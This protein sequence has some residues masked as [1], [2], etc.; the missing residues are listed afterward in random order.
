VDFAQRAVLDVAP[1]LHRQLAGQ[2]AVDHQHVHRRVCALRQ[3][4][5]DHRLERDHLAA[6]QAAVGADQQLGPGVVDAQGQVVR[7]EAAEHHRVHRADARASQ[8]GDG[9][10]HRVRHV[11]H[12][13]VALLH[14]Q[15]A[16]CGCERVHLAVQLAEGQ[17]AHAVGLAGPADQGELVAALGQVPVHRV[18]AQVGGAAGEPAPERGLVVLQDLAR[19]LLPLDGV[20][21]LGP[22]C[23]GLLDRTAIEVFVTHG[24][25]PLRGL[26]RA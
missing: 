2:V 12:H 24:I 26:D 20:G 9:R 18:V 21:R 17:L 3:R 8:H 25:T 14:A 1:W 13:P 5:V 10:I 6:A 22:E 23:F 11:D 4:L 16:Q 15:R 7:G 19:R